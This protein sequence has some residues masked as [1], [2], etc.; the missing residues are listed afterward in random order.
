[1]VTI[2]KI[3]NVVVLNLID[4]ILHSE[5]DYIRN[6]LE[7]FINKKSKQVVVNLLKTN[8]ICSSALGQ[9]VFM[10]SKFD[11]IGGDIVL[12]LTDEDLLELFEITMLDQLFRI[13]SNLDDA[14]NSYTS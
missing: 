2:S 10:K 7:E 11:S 9:I 14:V 3:K 4:T 8:H 6:Q 12:V 13:Y 5:S 1:L